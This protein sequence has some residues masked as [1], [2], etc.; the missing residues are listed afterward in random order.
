MCAS[1][2]S[3]SPLRPGRQRCG[4]P[5]AGAARHRVL[6]RTR[7]SWNA[8]F[9]LGGE[10]LARAIFPP[11]PAPN[12]TSVNPFNTLSISITYVKIV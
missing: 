11:P 4:A 5:S 2:I 9:R 1:G 6:C 12:L 8:H 7:R 3:G 10:G